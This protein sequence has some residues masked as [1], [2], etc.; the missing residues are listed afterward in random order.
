MLSFLVHGDFSKP[1]TGLDKYPKEDRPPVFITFQ[2]YHLMVAMGMG[3]IG[4]TLLGLV[5]LK[6][7][8]L[9]QQRW[10]L[11]IYVLS[12]LGGYAANEGGWVAAE[13]GRQPWVVYGLL[14]T[15]DAVSKAIVPEHVIASMVLFGVTYSFLFFVWVWVMNHRIQ[16][17]PPEAQKIEAET[18]AAPLK[19]DPFAAIA[20]LL[21]RGPS[22]LS[23]SWRSSEPQ[24]VENI[25]EAK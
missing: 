17:G 5:F 25:E 6:L 15:K 19:K 20:S 13:V 22:S 21:K 9:Y 16:A 10:L 4:I 18:P 14:R 7:G 24:S 3:F 12:V 8:T 1:V 11:W 2:A 23:D